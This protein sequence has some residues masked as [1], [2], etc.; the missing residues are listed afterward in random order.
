P[1]LIDESMKEEEQSAPSPVKEEHMEV[2]KIDLEALNHELVAQEITDL[3][4]IQPLQKSDFLEEFELTSFMFE[5][6]ASY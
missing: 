1:D 6:E 3:S 2:T 4:P 5:D